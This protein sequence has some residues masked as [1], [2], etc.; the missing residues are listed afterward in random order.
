MSAAK[1]MELIQQEPESEVEALHVLFEEWRERQAEEK[2]EEAV[3][4]GAFD[5]LAEQALK[6]HAEGKT[7]PLN[8]FLNQR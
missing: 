1:I 4:S 7:M 3:L 8:E 2:W 6:E 5:G